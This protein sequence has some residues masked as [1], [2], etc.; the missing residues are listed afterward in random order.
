VE[1]NVKKVTVSN[2]RLICASCISV[3]I[4]LILGVGVLTFYFAPIGEGCETVSV[5]NFVGMSEESLADDK[6]FEIKREWVY[7]SDEERGRVISQTP[8]ANSKRKIVGSQKREVTVC[9]GLGEKTRRVPLLDG[10]DELSAARALREIGA[11]VRS[12]AIYGD[13][14]GGRVVGTSPRAGSEVKE[15]DTVT[16]YVSRQRI[17]CEI[18]V[19]NFVGMDIRDASALALSMG[20]MLDASSDVRGEIVRQSIPRDSRVPMGS[21]ISFKTDGGGREWPPRI[22]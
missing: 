3:L 2:K 22:K 5:P 13:V 20:L 21:Y 1:E 4:T 12:V 7:S 11:R 10:V 18:T 14:E 8:I 17:P 19:P 6:F 15:G 16:L 9:I